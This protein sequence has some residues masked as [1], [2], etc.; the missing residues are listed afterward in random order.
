MSKKYLLVMP[1]HPKIK[2]G[3]SYKLKLNSIIPVI[4]GV[5]MIP[6]NYLDFEGISLDE[7]TTI[8]INPDGGIYD[9]Y[10]SDNLKG[11]YLFE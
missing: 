7:K 9:I 6:M 2:V 5:K 8:N 4:N 1:N 10:K 11:L 3:N